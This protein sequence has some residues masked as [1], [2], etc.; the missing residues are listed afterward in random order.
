MDHFGQHPK[1]V[2][3]LLKIAA[4]AQHEQQKAHERLQRQVAEL[5]QQVAELK[6]GAAQ[7]VQLEQRV[8]DLQTSLAAVLRQLPSMGGA[9]P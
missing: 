4:D 2:K 3:T 1:L 5:Q 7:Q 8:V 6:A 9:A